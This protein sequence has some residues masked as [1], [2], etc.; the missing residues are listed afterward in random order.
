MDN[1]ASSYRRFLSGDKEGL[2]EIVRTYSDGL[3]FYLCSIVR[4]IHTAEDLTEDV[5]AVLIAKK[6]RFSGKSSFKTWLYS[7][8]RNIA[9]DYIK[10]S[11]KGIA[12]DELQEVADE[13]DLEERYI[14]EESRRLLHRA[15]S[16]LEP[17]YSQVLFLMWIEG[18]DTGEAAH[19][20]KK[21]KRQIGNLVFR[22]KAAL[23]KELEKEGIGNEEL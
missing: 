14:S 19:I 1:G 16:R 12:L 11:S 6:P 9:Y 8:G 20:M 10:S 7:I 15:I 23:K 4:D 2:S 5:F 3:I 13:T 18:F 22:A 17:D 21:T